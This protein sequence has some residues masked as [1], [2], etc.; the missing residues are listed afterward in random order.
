MLRIKH[1][2]ETRASLALIGL[3]TIVPLLGSA[4]AAPSAEEFYARAVTQMRGY[5]EPAFA[6]YDASISGLNCTAEKAGFT[7]TLGKSTAQSEAPFSIDLRQ[8]DGRVA[9]HRDGQSAVFGDSTFLNATWPGVD[10][11]IRRGFT[12]MGSAAPSTPSPSPSE[13][14]SSFPVIAVVSTLSVANYNVYDAGAATCPNGNGGHALRLV[15]RRE[16]L[17]YPLTGATVDVRTGDLCALGFNANVN[18]AGGLVG[19]TSGAKIDLK[20][21]GGYDVVTN[22]RF[23]IDLRAVGIAVKHLTI[24]VAYSN[25]S[26]PKSIAP[27]VFVTPA[28][29]RHARAWDADRRPRYAWHDLDVQRRTYSASDSRS[30]LTLLKGQD[31]G[32]RTAWIARLH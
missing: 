18:A 27:R 29:E 7:C 3:T 26:F 22:E 10:A 31:A 17:R 25:F 15:A 9:L 19:A 4:P 5:P 8:S 20:N 11:L 2:I 28:P 6:T 12:G 16:P 1:M 13:E 24:N 32:G 23:D 14:P 30:S 21:V